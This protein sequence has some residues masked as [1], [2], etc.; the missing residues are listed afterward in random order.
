MKPTLILIMLTAAVLTFTT[1][2]AVAAVAFFWGGAAGMAGGD[3]TTSGLT[4]AIYAPFALVA[5]LLPVM[6]APMAR[7]A[8]RLG[9]SNRSASAHPIQPLWLLAAVVFLA[10]EALIAAIRTIAGDGAY[11]APLFLHLLLAGYAAAG[12][13]LLRRGPDHVRESADTQ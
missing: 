9:G 3:R 2:V 6:A 5:L 13:Y 8:L 7:L 4:A 10:A 12:A 1:L 11:S